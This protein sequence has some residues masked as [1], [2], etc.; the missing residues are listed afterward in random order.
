MI[1]ADT[2]AVFT[3][4]VDTSGFVELLDGR[5]STSRR[6][7]RSTI[8]QV[9]RLVIIGL[10]LGIHY[11]GKATIRHAHHMLT[12]RLSLEAQLA[13]G[14][15]PDPHTPPVTVKAMY[16]AWERV[17]DNTTWTDTAAPKV[18]RRERARRRRRLNQA[19]D[20]L[21]DVFI[22]GPTSTSLALDATGIRSW[23]TRNRR[24]R[25]TRTGR[26]HNGRSDPDARDGHKTAGV[27]ETTNLYGYDSHTLIQVPE[28]GG[29]AND[30]P[31][32][33]RRFGVAPATQGNAFWLRQLLKR[34]PAT[35]PVTELLVDRAYSNL[36]V[37]TWADKLIQRS[38]TQ[39]FD[40]R[41]D[42]HGFTTHDGTKWTAG[43]PHCPATP[44]TLGTITRPGP[45]GTPQQHATFDRDIHRRE[46]HAL[47]VVEKKPGASKLR[48]QCPAIYGTVGCPL[49]DGTVAIAHRNGLPIITNPP[50]T[51]Q[52]TCCTH[53]TVTI[54][55]NPADRKHHQRHYWGSRK[56]RKSW[57][58]R[59]YIEGA[60]GQQRNKSLESLDRGTH[61]FMGLTANTIVLALINASYN[62]RAL[63]RWNDQQRQPDITHPLLRPRT[64]N[65]VVS[66]IGIVA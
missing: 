30:Y 19:C 28:Y 41:V 23:A 39:V 46:Q 32:L 11:D 21:M 20:Q 64:A 61:R 17:I 35:Q 42:D 26:P 38:I 55:M 22:I 56:W 49:R 63:R 12:S 24:S 31:L 65:V 40:L 58:R 13:I 51:A 47:H 29:A 2:A 60:F 59:T 27:G 43:R 18:S 15:R 1:T 6:G 45:M 16:R 9:F 36:R 10:F 8:P 44:D 25:T 62:L 53:T 4:I 37:D 57:N 7:R 54:S 14:V 48:V 66:E 3:H 5:E 50:T 34:F 33:I 52:P